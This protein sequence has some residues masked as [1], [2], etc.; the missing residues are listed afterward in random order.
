MPT[1]NCSVR[2]NRGCLLLLDPNALLVWVGSK[3]TEMKKRST[4]EIAAEY[5]ALL[6]E[7]ENRGFELNTSV[8][9]EGTVWYLEI[10][11]I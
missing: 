11:D 3:S 9:E 6:K 8:I 1:S 4:L 10:H 5:L 2:E 7:R